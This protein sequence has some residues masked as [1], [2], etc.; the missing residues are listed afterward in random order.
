MNCPICASPARETFP[1]KHVTAAKCENDACGHLWAVDV[2]SDHGLQ[3]M[4]NAGDRLPLY[5]E[6]NR[7]IVSLFRRR[8]F[9]RPN[10]R[11][12]DMGAGSGHLSQ[13]IRDAFSP[14][15]VV[16]VEGE[17]SSLAHL[18]S[19]GFDAHADLDA[20]SGTFDAIL[21]TEVIEHLDDPV[22]FLRQLR[23][24]LNPRG[25]LFCTT[26]CGETRVGSRATNAYDTPEHAHFFTERS[27]SYAFALAGFRPFRCETLNEMTSRLSRGP[28]R[29]VKDIL[30]PARAALLGHQHLTGFAQPR[31]S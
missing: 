15:E 14:I 11:V 30:R 12:L 16:A 17:P 24:L 27:L 20:I 4:G 21:L 26:P 28:A 18:R 19:V 25:A 31:P 9:I 22:A 23:P 13:T 8:G 7:D 3:V 6:R 2:P 1:A 10:M 5:R 29:I